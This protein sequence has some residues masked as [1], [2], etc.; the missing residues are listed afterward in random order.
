M[1]RIIFGDNQFFG[2]NHSSEEKSRAQALKFKTNQS[3]VKVLDIIMDEGIHT[4]MCTTHNR[5]ADI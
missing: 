4:F 2:I 5:I 1:E 3:I